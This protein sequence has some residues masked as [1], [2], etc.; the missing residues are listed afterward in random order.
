MGK[1]AVHLGGGLQLLF[2]IKGKRWDDSNYGVKEF[3]QYEGLMDKP[4]SLFTIIIGFVHYQVTH[5]RI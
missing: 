4:Y 2:G 3:A 1:T 5:R